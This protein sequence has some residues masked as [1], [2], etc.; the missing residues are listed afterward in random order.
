MKVKDIEIGGVY[1]ARV[2]HRIVPIRV[3]E[4]TEDGRGR[5]RWTCTNTRTG[6]TIVVKSS[7]RFRSRVMEESDGA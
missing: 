5:R 7:Q 6:R 1:L 4:V 3:V 2:S